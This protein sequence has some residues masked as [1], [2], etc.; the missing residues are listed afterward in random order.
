MEPEL[1]EH[2]RRRGDEEGCVLVLAEALLQGNQVL[3]AEGSR[4]IGEGGVIL[5]EIL[6]DRQ[7]VDEEVEGRR[8]LPDDGERHFAGGIES[9][10]LDVEHTGNVQFHLEKEGETV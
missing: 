7:R 5:A 2:R 9:R 1:I 3:G 8:I 6:V 4:K 10:R